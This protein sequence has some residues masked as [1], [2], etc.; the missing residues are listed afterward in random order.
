M[1]HASFEDLLNKTNSIYKLTV[2]AAKRASELNAGAPK[3]IETR[4]KDSVIVALEEIAEGKI[5][6]KKD[7]RSIKTLRHCEEDEVR[8]S[9][10]L[11]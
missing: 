4:N 8:R 5:S 11:K 2:L 3:L 9:N 6:Y 7:E 10:P 1:I